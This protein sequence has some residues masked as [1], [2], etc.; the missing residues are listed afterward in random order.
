MYSIKAGST[1]RLD[2]PNDPNAQIR[3]L[4]RFILHPEWHRPTIR[5]DI[6]VVH[7]VQP[8]VFGAN[9]QPVV[10][11]LPTHTVPYG[12]LVVTSGWGL[13]REGQGSSV[14][15]ILQAV[16]TPLVSNPQ[17][18]RFYP[19]R[20]TVDMLCAGFPQGGRATCHGDSGG[21]LVDRSSGRFVQLGAV[22]WARGCARPNAPSVYARVP[23]FHA[24]IRQNM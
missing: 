19:N 14:P 10:L 21:P 24:W 1:F 22:S 9:V 15:N 3:P 12:N 20:I 4:S 8:L 7:W 17:C 18:L 23:H 11:P 13:T 6:A 2:V 5:N 16:A